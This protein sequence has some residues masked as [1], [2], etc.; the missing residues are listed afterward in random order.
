MASNKNQHFVPRCYLRPFTVNGENAAINLYNIDRHRFI[1][2]APV[3]NQC[4]RD[5]FYGQDAELESAIQYTESTY[6][7]V[8]RD[9]LTPG[10]RLN[11]GHH[12]V[13]RIFWMLQNL[14]TE[15]ACKRAVEMSDD[16]FEVVRPDPS[17]AIN[18]KEA[19]QLA[20]GIFAD[21]MWMLSDL[22]VCLIKNA[23][24]I[25]FITSDDPA[26]LTNRWHLEDKRTRGRSFGMR[27]AGAL[28]LL[29]LSP[30][31]Y[32]LC[33]DPDIYSIANEA[34][35]MTVRK[36]SDVEILNQFQLFHCR[37]NLFLGD[38]SYSEALHEFVT[39]FEHQRP[40][41][42]HLVNFAVFD[43][44][45]T[46]SHKRYRVV[47]KAEFRDYA[48]GIMHSQ[49][50]HP[51]PTAWPSFLLRKNKGVAY[52]NGTGAGYLRNVHTEGRSNIPF[53]KVAAYG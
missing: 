17:F 43:G 2:G 21:S 31:I 27:A 22:K 41:V 9:V 44:E 34:G 12:D 42:R 45:Q 50:I 1:P 8:L 16:T 53:Y 26:I 11:Q 5:Y 30:K 48:D 36:P 19:V 35:W 24:D 29:P 33:Y 13:L 51:R 52:F 14:R 18:I 3:K 49:T 47:P 4:S 28:L 20:M 40:S 10:C 25:P 6:G 32:C 46:D 15:A 37:A 38:E 23:T 39:K 7:A